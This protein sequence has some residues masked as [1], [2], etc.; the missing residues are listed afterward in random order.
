MRP[1]INL[2]RGKRVTEAV[3]ILTYMPQ[4]ATDDVK[5]TILSAVANLLDVYQDDNP[6]EES[7]VITEIR[8][9]DGPVFKR[10]RPA[11][12]GRAHPI[13]KR[14][15]HLTVVVAAPQ[16]EDAELLA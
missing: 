4:H 7:L 9:D 1:V 15:C 13:Q 16:E 11:P 5:Q 6:D 14:S 2:V 10:Y 8:V 3:E 12:R